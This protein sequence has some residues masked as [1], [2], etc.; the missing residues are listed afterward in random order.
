MD[1]IRWQLT[2]HLLKLYQY[3]FSTRYL[4]WVARLDYYRQQRGIPSILG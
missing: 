1:P 3:G 2:Y 4:E